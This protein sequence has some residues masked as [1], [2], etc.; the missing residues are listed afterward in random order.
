MCLCL[1]PTSPSGRTATASGNHAQ[2]HTHKVNTGTG[3]ELTLLSRNHLRPHV[4]CEVWCHQE[5]VV[6]LAHI[7]D[8]VRQVLQRTAALRHVALSLP[9]KLVALSRLGAS[10]WHVVRTNDKRATRPK[11]CNSACNTQLIAGTQSP[12]R[13][14]WRGTIAL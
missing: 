9:L 2:L 8:R 5:P 13:T 1:Y 14:S 10:E 4:V 6:G 12:R 7:A 11:A 3:G